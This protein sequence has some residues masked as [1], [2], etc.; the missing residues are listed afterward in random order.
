MG[1]IVKGSPHFKGSPTI[2]RIPSFG[3]SLGFLGVPKVGPRWEGVGVNLFGRFLDLFYLF[4][5]FCMFVFVCFCLCFCMFAFV[6]VFV[7]FVCLVILDQKK[8][9]RKW[10]HH[11][12][13]WGSE[14]FLVISLCRMSQIKDNAVGC[15][16]LRGIAHLED[17]SFVVST[18]FKLA[19]WL[20]ELGFK[21]PIKGYM[22]V[23]MYIYI[24]IYMEKSWPRTPNR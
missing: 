2:N 24:Y 9:T 10:I 12:I 21:P 17:L 5:C 20:Q 1:L 7:C 18:H 11:Q 15:V 23:C 13:C 16:W 19:I 8:N 14:S 4:L 22:Y 6:Y 3:K